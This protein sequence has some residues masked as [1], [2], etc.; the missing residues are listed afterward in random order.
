MTL[1]CGLPDLLLSGGDGMAM[2]ILGLMYYSG[3]VVHQD[4]K[5]AFR[6]WKASAEIGNCKSQ[7]NL[8]H[9][10]RLGAGVSKNLAE[11]ARWHQRSADQNC[12]SGCRGLAEMYEKGEYFAQDRRVA[13]DFYKKA[14]VS[15]IDQRNSFGQHSAR[16]SKAK[17]FPR[18]GIEAESNRVE[19][20]LA[21]DGQVRSLGEILA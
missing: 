7:S 11:A 20:I 1:P 5:V 14:E 19:I 10:F 18:P 6:W 9:M 13:V 4:F 8:A 17:S 15:S 3:R 16:G 12:P 2:L 21:I